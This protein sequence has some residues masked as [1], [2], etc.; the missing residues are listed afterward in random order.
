M[1]FII[2]GQWLIA[3]G[4][5]VGSILEERHYRKQRQKNNHHKINKYLRGIASK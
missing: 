4:L 1:K 3:I 5:I 2:I